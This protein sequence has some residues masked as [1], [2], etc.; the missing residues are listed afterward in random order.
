MYPPTKQKLEPFS[1]PVL[2]VFDSVVAFSIPTSPLPHTLEHHAKGSHL[3]PLY[4]F[5]E[6]IFIL[7]FLNES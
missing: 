1:R 4:V 5:L 3:F 6:S 7:V 2:S